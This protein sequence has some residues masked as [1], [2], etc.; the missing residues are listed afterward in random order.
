MKTR[1][2]LKESLDDY[3]DIFS[4]KLFLPDRPSTN[5][6]I[7]RKPPPPRRQ[8]RADSAEGSKSEASTAPSRV[9]KTTTVPRKTTGKAEMYF[10]KSGEFTIE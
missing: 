10:Y 4:S 1:E 6:T 9:A 7:A 2:S 8:K 3:F 5:E